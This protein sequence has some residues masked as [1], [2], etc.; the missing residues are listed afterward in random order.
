MAPVTITLL[1]TAKGHQATFDALRDQIA[2][3]L[4]LQHIVR[5]DFLSRAQDAMTESLVSEITREIQRF[6]TPVLCTC[7]T[8]GPIA[9]A[10]GALRIDAPMMQ[11]AADIG[12]PVLLVYCLESTRTPSLALLIRTLHTTKAP[13]PVRS[14]PLL[15]LWPLFVGGKTDEF[16]R[17]IATETRA[18]LSQHPDIAVIVLAQASM[19]GGAAHLADLTQPVLTSPE[20]ALRAAIARL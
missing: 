17:A 3:G 1:H 13:P 4:T 7:T 8:I 18:Y 9:E 12:G 2:P 11:A 20:H 14:L 16:A 10:A 6:P 19:A 15:H 5:P